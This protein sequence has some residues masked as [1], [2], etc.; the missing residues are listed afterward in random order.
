MKNSLR[1]R[2]GLLA[3]LVLPMA[4]LGQAP[5]KW[6]IHDESRPAPPVVTPGMASTQNAAGT[7]PS[8]AIVL[9]DGKDLSKWEHEN[10]SAAKWKVQNGFAEVVEKTG[11]IQTKQIF[12]DVQL[13]VE[14]AEPLPA[15]G[16]SQDRGNS[17]V[18]LANVY[19]VQVLDSYQNKTYADG[20]AASLYGQYPPQV[21]ASRPP[22][23]W[24]SYDVVFHGPRFDPAGKLLRPARVTVIHNG[25]LVQD[26]VELTGP[27][28]HGSRPPYK[29]GM[30]RGPLGLQD[31]GHPVR[32][33]NI[34]VR[35]L[36]D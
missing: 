17:G 3:T 12:G 32:Y 16:E 5:M 29:P 30:D 2:L 23:Q 1:V 7:A 8:D 25:V 35:E 19:E 10:K 11:N 6:K 33:R 15:E 4:C 9:F 18:F 36:A 24:Q 28:A 21:N 34:W 27:T 14:F 22:G 20:S 31:H 13:H 26:N